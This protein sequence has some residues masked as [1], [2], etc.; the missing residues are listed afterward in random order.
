MNKQ[1][2]N[3]HDLFKLELLGKYPAYAYKVGL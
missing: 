3:N 1:F 2:L